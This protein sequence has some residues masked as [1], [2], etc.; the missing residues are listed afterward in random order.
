MCQRYHTSSVRVNR[1]GD[2]LSRNEEKPK[3]E[4]MRKIDDSNTGARGQ[5]WDFRTNLVLVGYAC[6]KRI[7]QSSS[8]SIYIRFHI[9]VIFHSHHYPV[10]GR[11]CL[12]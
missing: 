7:P 11:Y 3:K 6:N 1:S 10:V 12:K 8:I 5:V 9:R 2:P 4:E